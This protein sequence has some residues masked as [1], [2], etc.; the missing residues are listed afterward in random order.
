MG[1]SNGDRKASLRLLPEWRSASTGNSRVQPV[2]YRRSLRPD[3]HAAALP[4]AAHKNSQ[5]PQQPGDSQLIKQQWKGHVQIAFER[6]T[7]VPMRDWLLEHGPTMTRL[8]ASEEIGYA[9][10]SA[11]GEYVS[12]YMPG[13]FRFYKKAAKLNTGQLISANIQHSQG[14]SWRAL[15]FKFECDIHLLKE[16][17]RRYRKTVKDNQVGA[18]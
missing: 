2:A 14:A 7:G 18:K 12:R 3:N 11:L 17:C 16:S 4:W 13:G 8:A 1:P 9:S 10:P 6:K 15:A 5:N